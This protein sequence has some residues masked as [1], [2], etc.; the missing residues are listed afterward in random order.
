M[1]PRKALGFVVAALALILLGGCEMLL[2]MDI[3]EGSVAVPD[4]DLVAGRSFAATPAEAA[5]LEQFGLPEGSPTAQEVLLARDL[6]DTQITNVIESDPA[7]FDKLRPGE[8]IYATIT[9][10]PV[11]DAGW[12]RRGPGN[13]LYFNDG[14]MDKIRSTR[15]GDTIYH[16]DLRSGRPAP[17]SKTTL[18][19]GRVPSYR[20]ARWSPQTLSYVR[21]G[22]GIPNAAGNA[23]DIY[24]I[25]GRFVGRL[26]YTSV[27]EMSAGALPKASI[28][29]AGALVAGSALSIQ[30]TFQPAMAHSKLPSCEHTNGDAAILCRKRL[31]EYLA[32]ANQNVHFTVRPIGDESPEEG[33]SHRDPAFSEMPH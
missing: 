19:E 23:V 22:F 33:D 4:A 1:L 16:D 28:F 9:N 15:I 11:T 21:T 7:A 31:Q 14:D 2:D 13:S 25:G 29:T 17:L 30:L 26:H 20:Y 8:R 32:V 5:E 24:D 6:A 12:V 3:M 18:V 10:G 27:T